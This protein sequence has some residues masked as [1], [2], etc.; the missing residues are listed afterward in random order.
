MTLSFCQGSFCEPGGGTQKD[1]PPFIHWPL[2]RPVSPS[3]KVRSQKEGALGEA[4]SERSREVKEGVPFPAQ[5]PSPPCRLGC[6]PS[7]P[8]GRGRRSRS[9]QVA[10]SFPG[11]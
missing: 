10:L 5:A 3:S 1:T 7:L 11:Y 6:P 2:T 9:R 8:R 4:G